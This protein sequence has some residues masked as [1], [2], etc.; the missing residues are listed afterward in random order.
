MTQ[1]ADRNRAV[2]GDRP[3]A[4]AWRLACLLLWSLCCESAAWARAG[5]LDPSFSGNGMLLGSEEPLSAA[6]IRYVLPLPSGGF[7]AI[8]YTGGI[9][10]YTA[11]GKLDGSFGT[12][13]YARFPG[14]AG[15]IGGAALDSHGRIVLLSEHTLDLKLRL[16]RVTANGTLDRSL[17]E[18]GIVDDFSETLRWATAIGVD[19]Q[20][21]IV[22]AGWT[23]DEAATAPSPAYDLVVSRF[24]VGGALER[25]FGTNGYALIPFR[26]PVQPT[27]IASTSDDGILIALAYPI[28]SRSQDAGVV[29]KLDDAGKAVESFADGGVA[30]DVLPMTSRAGLYSNDFALLVEPDQHILVTG[31]S[32][33]VMGGTC[34]TEDTLECNVC[35]L[36]PRATFGV[37]RLT[38]DGTRDDGFGEEGIAKVAF[39]FDEPVS[40]MRWVDASAK[41]VAR[42]PDGK[43]IVVGLVHALA[44]AFDVAAARLT[45]DG[46]PDP[47]FG[48]QGTVIVDVPEFVDVEEF[49]V[50]DSAIAEVALARTDGTILVVGWAEGHDVVV[51]RLQGDRCGNDALEDGELCDDG[52]QAPDDGCDPAC[53]ASTIQSTTTTSTTS[54]TTNSTSSTTSTIP[55]DAR[56]ILHTPF[57]GACAT[58]SVPRRLRTLLDRAATKLD[59]ASAAPPR[60]ARKLS[61]RAGSLLKRAQRA[62]EKLETRSPSGATCGEAIRGAIDSVTAGIRP[63]A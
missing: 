5:D 18:G 45:A 26:R 63:P 31:T 23:Y 37:A 62:A 43:V 16:V 7:V 41:G 56:C 11:E 39:P 14:V 38:P 4:L 19:A 42:Q 48:R 29:V 57:I 1:T 24:S 21:R 52:N 32:V 44:H 34:C 58:S 60:R 51:I 30:F 47:T 27:A 54:S 28:D 59:Q 6:N 10:R 20:D 13:G 25:T 35:P 22:V 55:C 50:S 2:G 61:S 9:V 53:G 3:G 15:Y 36:E 46:L 40:G 49:T 17:G 12:G 33:A 8:G